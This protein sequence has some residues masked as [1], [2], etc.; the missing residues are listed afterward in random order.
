MDYATVDGVVQ[1]TGYTDKADWYM[2]LIK[3]LLDNGVD[4]EWKYYP[5]SSNPLVATEIT[6]S[7]TLFHIKVR[8]TNPDNIPVF[9]NLSAIFDYDMTYGSKQN[10]RVISRGLLGDAAKQIGSWPYVLM[11]AEDSGR[12]FTN[13]QWKKP[14]IIRANKAE[15]HVLPSID[16]IHQKID[17][18]VSLISDK[19]QHTDTEV[20]TIW[21]IIEEVRDRLDMQTIQRFCR[22]YVIFT[23]DISFKFRFIDNS[24]HRSNNNKN[25][26]N[27]E[28]TETETGTK[29]FLSDLVNVITGPAPKAAVNIDLP[30][31]HSIYSKWNNRSSVHSINPEEFTSA[32]TTVHDK[33]QMKIYDV[34]RTFRE[35]SQLE[36]TDDMEKSVAELMQDPE[37]EK[38][39]ESYFRL[40]YKRLE[41]QERLSLPYSHI[42]PE[43]RKWALI[44]RILP[45]FGDRAIS[46]FDTERAVYKL[47]HEFYNDGRP[48]LPLRFPFAFEMMAIPL[49]DKVL[50]QDPNRASVLIT[51]VNY[52]VSPKSNRLA[53]DYQWFDEEE[54]YSRKTEDLQGILD[55]CGFAFEESAGAKVRLP[56]VIVANLISPRVDYKGKSKS[57]IDTKP[58]FRTIIYAAIKLAQQIPTFQGAGYHLV[59]RR[60]IRY[61]KPTK[62]RLTVEDVLEEVLRKRKQQAGI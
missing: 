29:D 35:G 60:L 54:E 42:K 56:S 41:P 22:K 30:A 61:D 10:Q 4:F 26:E 24:T 36:K 45:I 16:K 46:F 44:N 48:R 53:G 1:R 20:E 19:L 11:H 12:T 28:F 13:K 62:Q 58:F 21:P 37:K 5:G 9:Q 59:K 39:I 2:L 43:Q 34:L 15:Y 52:S 50:R 6:L 3:E 27:S 38:K 55:R 49:S 14:L 8:N 47:V 32:F 51:A 17:G 57:D 23:T 40:L 25:S 7:D 31:L 33:E 18:P